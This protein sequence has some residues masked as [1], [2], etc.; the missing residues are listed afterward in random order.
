[1]A[2]SKFDPKQILTEKIKVQGGWVNAHAHIDRAYIL[3]EENF[4]LTNAS[5]QEKWDFPDKYKAS[6]T[7]DDIYSNMARTLEDM[8]RQGVNAIGTFIDVDPVIKDKA[9]RAAQKARDKFKNDIEIKYINQV[10]KGVIEP[11]ARKWFEVGA[12]F[13]DIIGGLP[14]K[15]KGREE[16]HLDILFETAKKNGN[17]PLHVHV[18]QFNSPDQRDTEKL[19]K[20]TVQHGYEGK[21]TAIHCLSVAAQPKKYRDKLYKDMKD[22]GVMVVACPVAWI[23]SPRNEI[24]VPTHSSTTPVEEM[25][26]AGLTV[27]LG[28]DNIRDIYKPFA[29]GDMWTE[30]HLLLEACHMYDIDALADIATV[31]GLKTLGL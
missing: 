21:V 25:T 2:A 19:V 24:L 12:E 4:K 11:E 17:K 3:T 28:T 13:V 29:D 18:D 10:V 23:D 6:A 5:L 27:G 15:D 22:A 1:M 26:A 14:E 16:E 8:C 7:V 30:L 31:N 20:K 9:I